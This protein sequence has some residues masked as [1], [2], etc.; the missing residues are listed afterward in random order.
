[1][2]PVSLED[3]QSKHV[4]IPFH[5]LIAE[6]GNKPVL[7]RRLCLCLCPLAGHSFCW[8]AHWEAINNM[9]KGEELFG[10]M[11]SIVPSIHFVLPGFPAGPTANHKGKEAI[12]QERENKKD[13]PFPLCD[14]IWE[15]V[16]AV[17]V[18]VCVGLGIA[19]K[20]RKKRK[21]MSLKPIA[22]ETSGCKI[23]RW[24]LNRLESKIL[25]HFC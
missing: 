20:G 21:P 8:L 6:D 3:P 12:L 22:W 18:C 13:M 16:S 15:Y 10:H 14:R 19:R 5:H 17:C 1:M 23:F 7:G 24:S 2:K 4:Y 25:I 11:S 9:S